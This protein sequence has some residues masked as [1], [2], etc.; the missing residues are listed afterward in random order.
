MKTTNLE[1]MEITES[2]IAVYDE[3]GIIGEFHVWEDNDGSE[4]VLYKRKMIYLSK[5][6][7]I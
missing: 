1:Y 2:E 6:K 3:N 7:E 5:M 4:Y